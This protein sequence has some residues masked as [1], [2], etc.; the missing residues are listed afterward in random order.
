MLMEKELDIV[1]T[2][3][4]MEFATILKEL[5]EGVALEVLAQYPE[6]TKMI[7]EAMSHDKEIIQKIIDSNQQNADQCFM[8]YQEIL[9]DISL[10]LEKE[11]LTYEQ[12]LAL[13]DKEI[14]IAQ[15][16]GQIECQTREMNHKLLKVDSSL[17][18]HQTVA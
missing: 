12:R 15:M 8:F 17:D 10:C 1:S 3:E 4:V 9:R 2:K 13:I 7:S 16:I 11:D 18:R 5:P 14:E 6:F